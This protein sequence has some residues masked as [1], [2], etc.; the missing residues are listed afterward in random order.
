MIYEI[1]LFP[2]KTDQIESFKRAFDEVTHLLTRASGYQGHQL[3][4]GVEAASDFNLL[5][6]WETL[7]DHTQRFEASEDHD[8]FMM[9]LRK[10]LATD[11]T[12]R[13]GRPV[14]SQK[15]IDIFST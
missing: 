8:V 6:R 13:H 11:P 4:Q 2:V 1:A 3:V 15:R 10:Y 5:V 14:V 7:E 9:G 12:V